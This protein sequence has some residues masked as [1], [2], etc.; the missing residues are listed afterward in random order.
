MQSKPTSLEVQILFQLLIFVENC[1]VKGADC[2]CTLLNNQDAHQLCLPAFDDG[3]A[4]VQD[5][6]SCRGSRTRCNVISY[7]T[8]VQSFT[9]W[10]NIVRKGTN[11]R[12]GLQG[13]LLGHHNQAGPRQC[14]HSWA[15]GTAQDRGDERCPSVPY[16]SSVQGT[17]T[18]AG[19]LQFYFWKEEKL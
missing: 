16:Q 5:S 19:N 1:I 6:L 3:S 10:R 2:A 14:W 4:T 17:A 11:S 15:R 13:F 8:T 7:A 12:S 9:K 18:I